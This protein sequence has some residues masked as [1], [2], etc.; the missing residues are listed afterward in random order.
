MPRVLLLAVLLVFA[1]AGCGSD[2]P[3]PSRPAAVPLPDGFARVGGI[4]NGLVLAV[5]TEW[6]SVDLSKDTFEAELEASGLTGDALQQAKASL[7]ALRKNK[8]VYA[9][10]PASQ[11]ESPDKFVTNL[12]GFCQPSVGAS[13]DALIQIAKEQLTSVNATVSEATSIPLG[14]RSAVRI[15]Y[16]LP[17]KKAVVRG[18][19]FYVPSD[20]GQTCVVTLSTDLTGKEALFDQIG[21]TIRPL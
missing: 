14:N 13:A 3:P 10:D 19:Q 7:Q 2:S 9:M 20:K 11:A 18:T 5:P 16:T 12:N 8:A 1:A 21:S 15:R 4:S 6:R 17:I